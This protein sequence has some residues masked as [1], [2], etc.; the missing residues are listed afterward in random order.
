[1]NIIANLSA[2]SPDSSKTELTAS[3]RSLPSAHLSS[4]IG[5]CKGHQ[6]LF[7]IFCFIKDRADERQM[8]ILVCPPKFQ[9]VL[10][11]SCFMSSFSSWL[12]ALLTYRS[13]FRAYHH[14]SLNLFLS[15]LNSIINPYSILLIVVL[16]PWS[17]CHSIWG[18]GGGC[19]GG[20]R[21]SNVPVAT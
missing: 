2:C 5:M 18:R 20:F 4:G 16:L 6:V 15:S 21:K 17:K 7:Q 14:I 10:F 8:K 1:M 12:L 11:L 13:W 3:A 9:F 19:G